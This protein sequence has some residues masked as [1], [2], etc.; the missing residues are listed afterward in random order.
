MY[1]QLYIFIRSYLDRNIQ[2]QINTLTYC[3][4]HCIA[5]KMYEYKID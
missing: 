3:N 1:T 2:N 5:F 4:K